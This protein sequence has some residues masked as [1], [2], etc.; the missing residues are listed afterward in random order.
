MPLPH[1]AG[2]SR[3]AQE[4]QQHTGQH[5]V[6]QQQQP[7]MGQLLAAQ[8]DHHP[9]QQGQLHPQQQRQRPSGLVDNG[10]LWVSGDQQHQQQQRSM[11]NP[12]GGDAGPFVTEQPEVAWGQD[13]DMEEGG[14]VPSSPPMA[15]MPMSTL[16]PG[17]IM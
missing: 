16:P 9:E 4:A 6:Q 8:G 12:L 2:Q 7:H 10:S 17:A 5:M 11:L 1:A 13:D 14:A 3:F 15:A